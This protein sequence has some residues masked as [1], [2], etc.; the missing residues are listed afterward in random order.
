MPRERRARPPVR[1][2]ALGRSR[3]QRRR[4]RVG[5]LGDQGEGAARGG[6]VL[7]GC[8]APDAGGDGGALRADGGGRLAPRLRGA[9]VRT[10]RDDQSPLQQYT[11]SGAD[12]A[13]SA[14]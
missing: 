7:G 9:R 14:L 5:A 3:G 6:Q 12:A 11:E 4:F 10:V 2:T 13:G 1:R 8:P